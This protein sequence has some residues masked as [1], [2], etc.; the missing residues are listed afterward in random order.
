MRAA[1][2]TAPR[3]V[4]VVNDWP[5]PQCGPGDV[6]VSITATGICGTDL[7]YVQGQ[8]DI[9]PGGLIVG[10]EPFGTIVAVG[11]EVDRGRI[12]QR[13]AIEPNYPCGAC[14]PCGRGVPSLCTKRRS[15]VVNEQGFLA[16]RVAV[17][18]DFAWPLP[19][20]I[21]DED[22][23]CIEPLAVAMGAVRRA[24]DLSQRPR[25]AITGA[26]SIGRILTDL[27]VRRGIVPAVIDISSERV[28]RAV[29]MGA[30][31]AEPGE[32]FDLIFES[33]GAAPA[34]EAAVELLDAMGMLVV[35]GVG[36]DAFAVDMKTLVRRGITIIGSMIYDH[37]HDYAEVIR[38]VESGFAHPGVVLGPSYAL[39][40]AAAA[41]LHA[42]ASAD[43]TW[44]R[45]SGGEPREH[46]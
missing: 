33:S 26:G 24:G 7:A 20:S 29:A 37:P 11:A 9:A 30:R 13:V 19:E 41:L 25:I 39:H 36:N 34:A 17:P 46:D 22:A 4:T 27:L 18:A 5:E 32:H 44:I 45:I 8:R 10:H 31:A 38:T 1:V 21:T 28:E 2:L 40:D 3:E 23:A 6:V 16:E 42:G 14:Q 43:K 35:I 15:P 12:G